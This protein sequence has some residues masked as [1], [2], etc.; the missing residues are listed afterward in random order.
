MTGI[1]N[2]NKPSGWTSQDVVAKLRGILREKRVG[3]GGTLDPMATG[4]L[5]VFVGR[6]TRAVQFFESADKEYIAGLRL[7]ITTDTQDTTGTVLSQRPASVS[8]DELEAVL[9]A[10]RGG[11]MQTPPMYSAVKVGG[12]KLYE[13]A[14]R[15]GEIERDAR[16]IVV[17]KAEILDGDRFSSASATDFTIL[18]EVS[19]GTYIR[20]LCADI[21]AK[22]GVGG[23]MSS[24]VRIRAGEFVLE[25]SFTLEQI[26]HVVN[27]GGPGDVLLPVDSVFAGLPS[28]TADS[29]QEYEIR[30]GQPVSFTSLPEGKHRIYA[31]DGCFIALAETEY[32]KT[33]ILKSF[34][35]V[36]S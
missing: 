10:F 2:V 21:G 35:E 3:H 32:G 22:L 31:A 16:R 26:A 15:G 20:T 7:G 1:I 9:S 4:V 36:R 6:A 29:R 14:R 24:L 30:N 12:K 33:R 34:F 23:V 5:P 17:S 8:R 19:K 27:N 13:I 25:R 28:I 18:F 11:Q